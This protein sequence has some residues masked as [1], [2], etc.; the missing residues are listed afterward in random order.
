MFG[1]V[2]SLATVQFLLWGRLS[3]VVIPPVPSR[4]WLLTCI[5]SPASCS[6]VSDDQAALLGQPLIKNW[7]CD[8]SS[9][10]S[11]FVPE[12]HH[13]VHDDVSRKRHTSRSFTNP[14]L[15]RILGLHEVVFVCMRRKAGWQRWGT[16]VS[17]VLTKLS[18]LLGSMCLWLLSPP[19]PTHPHC[20]S[21]SNAH[22]RGQLS[23]RVILYI[24]C[25]K[26]Q[27]GAL[28]LTPSFL[29]RKSDAVKIKEKQQHPGW[30]SPRGLFAASR[31]PACLLYP[32]ALSYVILFY[33]YLSQC[34]AS[35]L[36]GI[37]VSRVIIRTTCKIWINVL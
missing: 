17:A 26:G 29:V 5:F 16:I 8:V 14:F 9:E 6:L 36:R 11:V 34:S 33:Y 7:G 23:V 13:S 32:V 21:L 35:Q 15:C 28:R 25:G 20:L 12:F 37:Q 4:P 19:P 10:V 2:S 22:P 31:V 27:R 18:V 30:L 1:V 24:L 3:C